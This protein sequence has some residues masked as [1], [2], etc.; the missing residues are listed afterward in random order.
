MRKSFY[1]H[2]IFFCFY[3]Q[4]GNFSEE[5]DIVAYS[6]SACTMMMS[7]FMMMPSRA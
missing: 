5:E 6:F 4:Y 3:V 2:C 1:S 7:L